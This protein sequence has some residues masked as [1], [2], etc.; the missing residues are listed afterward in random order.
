MTYVTI[1]ATVRQG[2]IELL[3]DFPLAE[4]ATLLVTVLDDD[5]LARLALFDHLTAG[6]QDMLAGRT[7]VISTEEE[8]KTH[9]DS[10]FSEA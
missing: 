5:M 6:M 9:L 3:D 8:L 7:S 1:R 10:V 2:K 4:D